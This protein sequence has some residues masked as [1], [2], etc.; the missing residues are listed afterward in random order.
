MRIRVKK[1]LDSTSRNPYLYTFK[2]LWYAQLTIQMPP[3]YQLES[4]TRVKGEELS[5]V[6]N[7]EMIDLLMPLAVKVCS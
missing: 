4:T 2:S 5:T 1:E 6:A 3:G 7:A